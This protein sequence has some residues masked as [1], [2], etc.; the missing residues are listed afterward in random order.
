MLE[1]PFLSGH[2]CRVRFFTAASVALRF[3][4][5]PVDEDERDR[6]LWDDDPEGLAVKR[7]CRADGKDL[8]EDDVER[9]D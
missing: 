3:A 1:G 6:F 5:G 2:T 4:G 7:R 8:R 9:C